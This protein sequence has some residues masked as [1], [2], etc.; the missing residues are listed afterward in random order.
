MSYWSFSRQAMNFSSVGFSFC[1]L[2]SC[3]MFGLRVGKEQGAVEQSKSAIHILD[4]EGGS[5]CPFI[6]PHGTEHLKWSHFLYVNYISVNLR[7]E[8][9]EKRGPF[10]PGLYSQ[11][12]A[13]LR[14]WGDP[15][16]PWPL[17]VPGKLP[18]LR[19]TWYA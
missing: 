5:L 10:F 13:E 11:V 12:M 6:K 2:W 16:R 1:L 7:G 8:R 15:P 9:S 19:D 14:L 17:L 3:R 4:S 18:P